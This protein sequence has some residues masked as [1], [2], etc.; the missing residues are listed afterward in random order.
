MGP[1]PRPP[2]ILSFSA[3]AQRRRGSQ[4]IPTAPDPPVRQERRREIDRE[5]D[6]GEDVRVAVVIR[7]PREEE[8]Q[9][10]EEDGEGENEVGWE[11]GME[12][13]VWEGLVGAEGVGGKRDHRA[14]AVWTGG[15][16]DGG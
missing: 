8:R 2:P 14:R 12:F 4:T 9:R 5:L 6:L 10:G 3:L 15:E 11:N 7:M 16:A 1:R 13:G